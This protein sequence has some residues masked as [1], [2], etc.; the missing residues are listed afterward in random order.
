MLDFYEHFGLSKDVRVTAEF[1]EDELRMV[2]WDNE[3]KYIVPF[4]MLILPEWWGDEKNAYILTKNDT[5]IRMP[6]G[7]AVNVFEKARCGYWH[8]DNNKWVVVSSC[9]L[10]YERIQKKAPILLRNINNILMEEDS[11]SNPISYDVEFDALF[12]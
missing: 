4:D 6:H 1:E 3:T 9:Y 10:G 7:L 5:F 8:Y 11:W 2:C 12:K